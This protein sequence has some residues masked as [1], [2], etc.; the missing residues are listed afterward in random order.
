MDLA[1]GHGPHHRGG[2]GGAGRQVLTA[3]AEAAAVHPVPV[4]GQR[5]ERELGEVS[6]GVDADRFI[7]R[8]GGQERG[9]ERAAVHVIT[10]VSYSAD[11]RRHSDPLC[12]KAGSF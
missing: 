5:R 11:Q 10:M 3:G 2:V 9:G 12:G 6:G 1:A 8:A 4:A 7:R